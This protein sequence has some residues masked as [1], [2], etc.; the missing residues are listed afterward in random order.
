MGAT[1]TGKGRPKR[2]QVFPTATQRKK[3]R[4]REEDLKTADDLRVTKKS[5][6][7][8]RERIV[9]PQGNPLRGDMP[10]E[11]RVSA[12]DRRKLRN[13]RKKI[14]SIVELKKMMEKGQQ[15]N[16][17]QKEKIEKEGIVHAEIQ[18]ILSGSTQHLNEQNENKKPKHSYSRKNKKYQ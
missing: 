4:Q 12:K 9:N 13:L 1:R 8:R 15:I 14:N 6:K 11:I 10:V 3:R 16:D 18:Q 17:L 5:K 2:P 7:E